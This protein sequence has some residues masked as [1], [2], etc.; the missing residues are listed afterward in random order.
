MGKKEWDKKEIMKEVSHI[1]EEGSFNSRFEAFTEKL[2]Q[3]E[4]TVTGMA[5]DIQHPL[6]GT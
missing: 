5:R 3:E 1:L 4:I 2:N 6:C